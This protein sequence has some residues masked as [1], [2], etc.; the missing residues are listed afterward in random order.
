M[1]KISIVVPDAVQP[2]AGPLL[3]LDVHHLTG[4]RSAVDDALDSSIAVLVCELDGQQQKIFNLI[5]VISAFGIHTESGALLLP[6]AKAVGALSM[7]YSSLP[8]V[9]SRPVFLS[10]A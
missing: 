6:L 10:S 5:F 8:S 7:A 4:K 2:Y 3:G 1:L 9:C